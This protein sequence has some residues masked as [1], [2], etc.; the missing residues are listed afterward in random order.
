M[1]GVFWLVFAW[2]AAAV[3]ITVVL[4]RTLA[5]ARLPIHLRWE[6]APIPHEKGKERYGGSYLEDYE[7]WKKGRDRSR[8]APIVYMAKE[9]FL[10]RGVWRKNR[11][12]WPFSFGLHGGVYLLIAAL[13]LQAVSLALGGRQSGTPVSGACLKIASLLSVWGYVLGT[14]G[15]VGLL[16]K[17]LLDHGLAWSNSLRTFVN[18]LFLGAVFVSGGYAWLRSADATAEANLF[19]KGLLAFDRS[20]TVPFPLV[21]HVILSLS[22]CIYLPFTS[23]VHFVAK[24]FMYH[25]VRWN[26]EPRNAD[27]ERQSRDLLTRSLSWDGKH[28]RVDGRRSW[29]DVTKEEQ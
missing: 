20:V 4:Y 15:S 26:D 28:A 11:S 22:F 7:W 29:A 16:F 17:R 9:I 21:I 5:I 3:F 19:I 1:S 23:M 12:L 13:F 27:M 25:G 10:M 2:G 6:L 18:L 14:V 24:Y 8:V